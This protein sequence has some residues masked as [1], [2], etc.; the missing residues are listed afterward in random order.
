MFLYLSTLLVNLNTRNYVKKGTYY[1]ETSSEIQNTSTLVIR[2]ISRTQV[3]L[4]SYLFAS[5]VDVL[6]NSDVFVQVERETSIKM[7]ELDSIGG[8]SKA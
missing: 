3:K 5:Y 6:Q 7:D 8:S 4:R 2:G 1:T